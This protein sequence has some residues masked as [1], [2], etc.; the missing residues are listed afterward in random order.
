MSTKNIKLSTLIFPQ[1]FDSHTLFLK[2]FIFDGE[3]ND[4]NLSDIEKVKIEKEESLHELKIKDIE[5]IIYDEIK[6]FF[7][8][9]EEFSEELM[10]TAKIIFNEL[11]KIK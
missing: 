11:K 3:N 7:N 6:V 9:D 8:N 4:D 2:V 1:V 10:S 5:S